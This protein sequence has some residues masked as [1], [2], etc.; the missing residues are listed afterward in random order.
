[1]KQLTTIKKIKSVFKNIKG[2]NVIL[3]YGSFGR[4]DANP[5]SDIDI[6]ILVD[7]DFTTQNL[8]SILKKKF[9]KEIKFIS[10][11]SLR[12]KVV[13]YFASQPKMEFA[14]CRNLDE[15]NRYYLGSEITNIKNTIIYANKKWE[16][17]IEEYLKQITTEHNTQ[18]KSQKNK[19]SV[20]DLIDKFIYEFES[21]SAMHRR[22]DAYKFY[23]YY[24]IALH[25]AIQLKHLSTGETKYNFLPKYFVPNI[26][27]PEEKNHFYELKGTLFLPEANSQK[28]KLLDFFYSS[29]ETIICEEK[30]K[31]L[32]HFL[33]WIYE[34]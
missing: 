14:I 12:N 26:L 3:L 24:N 11:V 7:E 8:I 30:Q 18:I 22:S 4:N 28:R 10:E 17:K 23:F 19:K 25:V 21:C 13:I 15:I 2:V 6:Q 5:N 31:E 29:I 1:M 32:K 33:E 20:L 27:K 16:R 9:A 34:R